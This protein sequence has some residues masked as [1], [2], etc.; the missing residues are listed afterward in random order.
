MGS[1]PTR[2]SMT[3]ATGGRSR[4]AAR[5]GAAA[6]RSGSVVAGGRPPTSAARAASQSAGEM[7]ASKRRAPSA[8]KAATCF[9]V[10]RA[11]SDIDELLQH[12]LVFQECGVVLG[13]GRGGVQ[14]GDLDDAPAVAHGGQDRRV[15]RGV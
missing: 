10:S 1:G 14:D 8:T 15:G 9:E 12:E 6:R 7:T 3:A 4:T 2:L 5:A 13:A 11:R